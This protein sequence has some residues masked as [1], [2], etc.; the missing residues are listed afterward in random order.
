MQEDY[1]KDSKT[2]IQI[3]PITRDR[4]FKLKFRR[5]YDQ[6]LNELCDQYEKADPQEKTG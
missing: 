6:F 2:S 4:L 5:T 3:S 1:D